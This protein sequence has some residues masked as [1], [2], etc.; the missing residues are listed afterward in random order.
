MPPELESHFP[1]IKI[2]ILKNNYIQTFPMAILECVQLITL[3]LEFNYL[4]II[5]S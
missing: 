2:L 3:S 4:S 5:P 1:E